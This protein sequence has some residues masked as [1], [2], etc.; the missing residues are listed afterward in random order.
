MIKLGDK[1]K[2]EITGFIG[3]AV[4]RAEYLNGCISFEVS[5]A[6]SAG[7]RYNEARWID[8][9]QL[10]LQRRPVLKLASPR[11]QTGGPGDR[12]KRSRPPSMNGAAWNRIK[13]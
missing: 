4:C 11:R 1:V 6:T 2:D 8:A 3:I 10:I 5:P 13:G 7:N 9:K 12:P